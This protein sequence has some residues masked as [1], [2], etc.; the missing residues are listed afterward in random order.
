MDAIRI[1]TAFA[2]YSGFD[3]ENLGSLEAGKLA[4]LVVLSDDPLTIDPERLMEIVPD[5]TMIDGKVRYLRPGAE[6]PTDSR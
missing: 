6:I 2:A 1:N 4:D 5:L 3:D